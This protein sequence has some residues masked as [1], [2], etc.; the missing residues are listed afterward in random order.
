[1]TV[2]GEAMREKQSPRSVP[3]PYCT[4]A[5]PAQRPLCSGI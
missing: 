1:M 2:Q 5:R 3:V 4:V